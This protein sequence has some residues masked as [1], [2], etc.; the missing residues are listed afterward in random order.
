MAQKSFED[1][2]MRLEDIVERLE[3]G[4][5]SLEK[6]LKAFEDGMRLVGF[7][8][9]KLEQ[10]DQR[11]SKLIQDSDGSLRTEPFDPKEDEDLK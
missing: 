3:Q 7:C 11:V 10:A 6:S 8:S 5:L 2:M 4:E 1:A 9:E